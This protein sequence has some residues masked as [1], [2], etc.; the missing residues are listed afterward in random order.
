MPL[1]LFIVLVFGIF[2]FLSVGL[3]EPLMRSFAD[4][5]DLSRWLFIAIPGLFAMLIAL[6]AFH[7]AVQRVTGLREALSRALLVALL[8]WIA[9]AALIASLWCPSHSALACFSNVLIV[10]A[11]VAGGPFSIGTVLAGLVV[12]G[13]LLKRVPWLSY[14]SVQ[15]RRAPKAEPPSAE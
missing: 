14:E 4:E 8:T 1:Q 6:F 13:V 11:V 2:G 9:V 7:R 12:G 5:A 15:W 10:T 3:I